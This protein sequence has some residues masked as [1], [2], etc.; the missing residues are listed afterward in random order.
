M[1]CF[2]DC[3]LFLLCS[4]SIL[5]ILEMFFQNLI[6]TFLLNHCQYWAE[7]KDCFIYVA[8]SVPVY[9]LSCAI[10][11]M[12]HGVTVRLEEVS[13]WFC[14]LRVSDYLL[15]F[16]ACPSKYFAVLLFYQ[17]IPRVG[18]GY[19][20]SWYLKCVY[21]IRIIFNFLHCLVY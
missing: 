14:C 11:C 20:A 1:Q 16:Y 10:Y 17:I 8:D 3:W 4:R 2:L 12:F 6:V 19:T 21:G 18:N 5:I 13:E 15:N 9:H 7:K